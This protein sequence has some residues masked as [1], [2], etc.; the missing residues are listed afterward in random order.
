MAFKASEKI[1]YDVESNTISYLS[2]QSIADEKVVYTE[3][4]VLVE[5]NHANLKAYSQS[6]FI[7]T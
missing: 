5:T 6:Y 1:N 3:N 2:F 7:D 4:S